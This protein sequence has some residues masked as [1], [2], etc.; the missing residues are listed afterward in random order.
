[1]TGH[2]YDKEAKKQLAALGLERKEGQELNCIGIHCFKLSFIIITAATF[3]GVIVSLILVARTRTF[4]KGDIYKRYR[5]AAT[6]TDQAEMA[7]V[8]KDD[9]HVMPTQK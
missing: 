1:M 7:R 3:F 6:V 2:L 4:Y 5:D 8:E 9:K